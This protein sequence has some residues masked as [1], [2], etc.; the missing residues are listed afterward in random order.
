M[1]AYVKPA[2][3]ALSISA[4]DMLCTGCAE[5]TK[6]NK[7]LSG[8]LEEQFEGKPGITPDQFFTDEEAKAVGA[9]APG[10]GECTIPVTVEG[11]CKY[12]AVQN[13]MT[14]LFNS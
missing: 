14:Q 1:K 13:S 5:G 3:M 9:F 11:Y 8:M 4:N 6:N 7:M 2:M 12:S 10:E